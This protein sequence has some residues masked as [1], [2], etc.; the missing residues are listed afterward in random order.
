MINKK[1]MSVSTLVIALLLFSMVAAGPA[2]AAKGGG[3]GGGKPGSG[4]TPTCTTCVLNVSPDPVPAHTQPTV[5]GT[6]FTPGAGYQVKVK[7]DIF[8]TTVTANSSGSFSFVYTYKD[9]YIP[10]SYTMVAISNGVKAAE[11]TFT[12]E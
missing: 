6:G 4:T 11:D 8:S 1:L 10:G 7:G 3:G 9:L 12:V 2:L 5:S